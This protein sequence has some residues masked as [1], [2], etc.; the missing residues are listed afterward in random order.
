MR[1]SVTERLD[2]MRCRRK[3]DLQ[4]LNRQALTP[5][6]PPAMA[7]H[8]GSAIHEAL[9]YHAKASIARRI[10]PSLPKPDPM[11]HLRDWCQRETETLAQQYREKVGVNWNPEETTRL[12]EGEDLA[13]ALVRNYFDRWGWENPIA[14]YEYIQTE[15]TF[16]IPLPDTDGPCSL[17]K[18]TGEI[19]QEVRDDHGVL[20][21]VETVVCPD[22]AGT[23]ISPGWLT[24]TF[25]GIATIPGTDTLWIVDHKT[26][27]QKPSLESLQFD[28]QFTGY[29]WAAQALFGIPVNGFLYDGI[30]KKLPKVPRILANGTMSCEWVDTTSLVVERTLAEHKQA[31]IDRDDLEAAAKFDMT[32]KYTDF[33]ARLKERESQDQTPFHT[34]FK[35][36]RSQHA[37]V[38]WERNAVQQYLDMSDPELKLYPNFR[39]EGCWDCDVTDLC[40]AMTNGEDVDWIIQNRYTK[41]TGYATSRRQT[42]TPQTVGTL[43]DL[44][45]RA[46]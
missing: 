19:T 2:F 38:N 1:I 35:L 26:Y 32:E 6:G 43:G 33:I 14:P 25:D 20:Q 7:L 10:D 41:S 40:G 8:L 46:S 21:D 37:I 28:D 15:V 36:D 45:G 17:C 23:S 22:C 4:S 13:A 44:S 29:C 11:Q 27:S 39:W 12:Q 3:W 5:V 24:G 18:L 34:R 16:R 42:M 31:A 30:N 9:D